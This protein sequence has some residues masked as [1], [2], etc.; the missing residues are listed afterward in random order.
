M[1]M[2]PCKSGSRPPVSTHFQT[3]AY[4]F[5]RALN[6]CQSPDTWVSNC[7]KHAVSPRMHSKAPFTRY[8]LLSNRPLSNRFDNRLYRVYKHST[9]LTTCLTNGCIVY[10]AGCR[11]GCT[12]R[13]DN[14]V[15]RTAVPSTRLSSPFDN[16]FD[17]RLCRVNGV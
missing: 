12:T 8:N 10:T 14:R 15:E 6:D 3:V 1:P 5:I 9:R 7:D 16:R 11:T 13:F 17:N 4:A 2:R